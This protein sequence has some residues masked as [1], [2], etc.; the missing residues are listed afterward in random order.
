VSDVTPH[1]EAAGRATA[2]EIAALVQGTLSGDAGMEIS[3]VCT[4]ASPEAGKLCFAQ[5]LEML[6][7]NDPTERGAILLAPPGSEQIVRGTVICVAAPRLAFA[8]AAERVIGARRQSGV[9]RSASVHGTAVIGENV[10]IGENCVIGER[11]EIGDDTELRHNIV[12][13]HGVRIGRR[14][15]IK[16]NCV[17]GEEGF[18][19][20]KDSE[21]QNIRIP[22]VGSVLIEDDV[23][24]GGSTTVVAGTI[25]PTRIRR[26]VKL[27]D[28]VFIAH[29]CDIGA[30]SLVIACAEVSGSVVIGENC[31]IGPNASIRDGLRIAPG[32]LVGIGS[33]VTRSI[34]VA[35]VY[36]G[37]PARLMKPREDPAAS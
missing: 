25:S 14:C 30:D 3:G 15:L 10:T 7:S 5:S 35:G 6:S 29:N 13:A 8:R 23:E 17:L 9:A 31:W 33:V 2:G 18:G 37:V 34:E 12:V 32:S 27:D 20:E 22:H 4:F 1:T 19:F 28:H 16:S 21:G 11:V 36:A 26:G 24:I